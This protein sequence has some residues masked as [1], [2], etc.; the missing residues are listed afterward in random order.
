MWSPRLTPQHAPSSPTVPESATQSRSANSCPSIAPTCPTPE[1]ALKKCG[2]LFIKAWKVLTSSRFPRTSG[3]FSFVPPGFEIVSPAPTTCHAL[4]PTASPPPPT[5]PSPPPYDFEA[6]PVQAPV[7]RSGYQRLTSHS[8][9]SI[10]TTSTSVMPRLR[11]PRR[12]ASG[13]T[14]HPHAVGGAERSPPSRAARAHPINRPRPLASQTR[15]AGAHSRRE[16]YVYVPGPH[17]TRLPS[18]RRPPSVSGRVV[19]PRPGEL[20]PLDRRASTNSSIHRRRRSRSDAKRI[21]ADW[22]AG[23]YVLVEIV[24]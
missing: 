17:V 1:R 20:Q 5:A 9:T 4:P 18:R 11:I 12:T 15:L 21:A 22:R 24:N 10:A 16:A 23:S 6:A 19:V 13:K 7:Q 3:R 8:F 14:R 2:R